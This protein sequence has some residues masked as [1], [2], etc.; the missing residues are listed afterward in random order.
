MAESNGDLHTPELARSMASFTT[1]VAAVL[2]ILFIYLWA[3]APPFDLEPDQSGLW[4]GV[5]TLMML[6]A[7]A[8]GGCLYNLRGITKHLGQ[9]DFFPRYEVSYLVRP[10]SGGLCGLF[11]FVLV[12]GGVLTLSVTSVETLPNHRTTMLYVA[13][14]LLAGYGSHEFLQKVKD[15]NKAIFAL[16]EPSTDSREADKNDSV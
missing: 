9:E 11:V 7:G 1:I 16:K 14:S 2:V 8:I 3:G 15:L 12:Y 4:R 13:I 10:I 5:I 6:L